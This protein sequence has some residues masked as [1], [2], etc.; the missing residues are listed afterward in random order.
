MELR[1]LLYCASIA[2]HHRR[3]EVTKNWRDKKWE[4]I[5]YFLKWLPHH[6]RIYPHILTL[7]KIQMWIRTCKSHACSLRVSTI[8]RKSAITPVG[9]SFRWINSF[10]A[11]SW[12]MYFFQPI[13][14]ISYLKRNQNCYSADEA[15]WKPRPRRPVT[16]VHLEGA[17]VTH[18]AF[19]FLLLYD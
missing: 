7:S 1:V 13:L 5:F 18:Q 8:L 11:K 2:S 10:K 12:I 19:K 3:D 17:H 16:G 9:G 15:H 14:Y 6:L 4:I